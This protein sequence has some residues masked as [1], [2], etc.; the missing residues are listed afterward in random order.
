MKYVG[1]FVIF[2]CCT[3]GGMAVSSALTRSMALLEGMY[4]FVRYVRS[5]VSY[6]KMPLD[7]ICKGFQNECFQKMGLDKLICQVGLARAIEENKAQLNLSE[8]TYA[9]LKAFACRMGTL[10]YDEQISDCD[11]MTEQLEKEITAK[12]NEFP[13]KKR[14]YSSM[15]VLGG[16]MAVL[17]LL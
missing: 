2:I 17:I 15:G 9:Q 10:S 12:K 13:A 11:Y 8:E 3:V 14:I 5:Q 4:Q 6:F 16:A 7:A 1:L